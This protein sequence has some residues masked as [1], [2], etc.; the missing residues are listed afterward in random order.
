MKN[1]AHY[2]L[3]RMNLPENRSP[4]P[5]GVEGMLFGIMRAAQK[6]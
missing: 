3:R 4:S 1:A 2:F 6:S 5:I